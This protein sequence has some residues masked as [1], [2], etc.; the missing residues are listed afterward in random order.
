VVLLAFRASV[1]EAN[2][3]RKID[4]GGRETN[5]SRIVPG[6]KRG[7]GGEWKQPANPLPSR[8]KNVIHQPPPDQSTIDRDRVADDW[9]GDS[10]A[11][12]A[13]YLCSN[14]TTSR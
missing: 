5:V 3:Q 9:T 7:F 14:G 6:F 1:R 13:P 4:F 10:G 12:T 11:G 8:A 2:E